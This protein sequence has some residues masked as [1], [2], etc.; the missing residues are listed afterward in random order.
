M[1]ATPY[2][3]VSWG[4][5]PILSTKLAQMANNDQWIFENMPI[6]FFNA[7]GVIKNGGIKIYG[8]RVNFPAY[9]NSVQKKE[10]YFSGRFSN[11]CKPIVTTGMTGGGF[12]RK[13]T[14]ITGL[15]GLN[16]PDANGFLLTAIMHEPAAYNN[17][18]RTAFYVDF[19]AIGW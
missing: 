7:S 18:F 11:G 3:A 19:I 2:K 10:V 15:G 16:L 14:L 8:G 1:T 13:Q 12:M 4:D 17:Q 5:E 6:G 9:A